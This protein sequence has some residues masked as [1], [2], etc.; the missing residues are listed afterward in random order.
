[1]TNTIEKLGFKWK[2]TPRQLGK[3]SREGRLLIQEKCVELI[4]TDKVITKQTRVTAQI[5]LVLNQL[6]AVEK[7]YKRLFEN[8]KIRRI[9][10]MEHGITSGADK[11]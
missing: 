11:A 4:A 1:V 2:L 7:E 9:D 6:N 5:N 10:S 3:L 8:G